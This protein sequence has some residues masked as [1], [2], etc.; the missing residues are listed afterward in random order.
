MKYSPQGD[1]YTRENNA[2][3]CRIA[4][5]IAPRIGFSGGVVRVDVILMV[6]LDPRITSEL[7]TLTTPINK[8]AYPDDKDKIIF[9]LSYMEGGSAGLWKKVF[10]EELHLNT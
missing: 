6:I 2:D 1:P 8:D 3:G 7:S 4:P 5:R 10:M 9:I